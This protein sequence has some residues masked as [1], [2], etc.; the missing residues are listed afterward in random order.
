MILKN[1]QRK[2]L[3]NKELI[4]FLVVFGVSCNS[5]RDQSPEKRNPNN[6]SIAVAIK[7][8]SVVFPPAYLDL[9]SKF[10]KDKNGKVDDKVLIPLSLVNSFLSEKIDSPLSSSINPLNWVENGIW[11]IFYDQG[12]L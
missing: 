5:G 6:D 8:D 2:R 3:V 11:N 12:P 10:K 7:K 4:M 1:P 9:R